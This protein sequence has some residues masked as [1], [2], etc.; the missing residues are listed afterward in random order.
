MTV[1]NPATVLF[2]EFIVASKFVVLVDT[3][4]VE[5]AAVY[6]K[7]VTPDTELV[8]AFVILPVESIVITGIA[9]VLPY[10]LAVTPVA[11][12]LALRF[13]AN[14]IG[15]PLVCLTEKC[16]LLEESTVSPSIIVFPDRNTLPNRLVVLPRLYMLFET[17]IRSLT[18]RVPPIVSPDLEIESTKLIGPYDTISIVE[19]DNGGD[20]NDIL[21]PSPAV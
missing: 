19:F 15:S 1:I 18:L 11:G 7:P 12:K 5:F 2:A 4:T 8:V 14:A 17:G 10:V 21:V 9:V 16:E 20:V 13:A 3:V 6:D